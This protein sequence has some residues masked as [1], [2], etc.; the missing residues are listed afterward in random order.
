MQANVIQGN[1]TQEQYTEMETIADQE[2]T[3]TSNLNDGDIVISK[4]SH[5]A[6]KTPKTN[7]DYSGKPLQLSMQ[8]LINMWSA[9][10][11]TDKPYAT[12]AMMLDGVGAKDVEE[13]DIMG[14]IDRWE[15]LGSSDKPKY[16]K[17]HTIFSVLKKIESLTTSTVD[18]SAK[19]KLNWDF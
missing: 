7:V 1:F 10:L 19:V 6:D 11:I 18:V 17:A 9:G 15:G 14:F 16:L 4:I 8:Q 3:V 12:L 13:F 2:F 5:L